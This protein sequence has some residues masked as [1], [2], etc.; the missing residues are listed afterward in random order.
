MAAGLLDR[1]FRLDRLQEVNRGSWIV[2]GCRGSLGIGEAFQP[3][4]SNGARQMK[5]LLIAAAIIAAIFAG[6]WIAPMDEQ[7]VPYKTFIVLP[8]RI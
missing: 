8:H 3:S 2:Y 5:A 4:L 7:H 1:V 6:A